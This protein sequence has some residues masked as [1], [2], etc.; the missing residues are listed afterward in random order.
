M[1]CMAY[2]NGC[3]V[4]QG[5]QSNTLDFWY[6]HQGIGTDIDDLF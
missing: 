6:K 1:K 3:F 4:L 2:V 5:A